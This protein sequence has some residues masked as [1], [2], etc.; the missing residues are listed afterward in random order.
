MKT[1]HQTIAETHPEPHL[2]IIFERTQPMTLPLPRKPQRLVPEAMHDP[3][4]E[5]SGDGLNRRVMPLPIVRVLNRLH[6]AAVRTPPSSKP[7]GLGIT[8][9][10]AKHEPMPPNPGAATPLAQTS[11]RPRKRITLPQPE[12]LLDTHHEKKRQYAVPWP[13]AAERVRR[14]T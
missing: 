6:A 7:H 14:Q 8:I 2:D 5:T 9:K 10:I 1:R 12:N 4:R 11:L 3:I 13:E